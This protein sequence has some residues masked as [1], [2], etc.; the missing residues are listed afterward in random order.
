MISKIPRIASNMNTG[1]TPTSSGAKF[2]HSESNRLDQK[3]LTESLKH[4]TEGK[5]KSELTKYSKLYSKRKNLK[6]DLM[7][8]IPK[9]EKP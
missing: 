2:I 6:N 1:F 5:N 7:L 4:S 9:P 8:K 3:N